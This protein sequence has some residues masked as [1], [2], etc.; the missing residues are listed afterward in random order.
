MKA[1][2][3]F[4]SL[5]IYVWLLILSVGIIGGIF[6]WGYNSH[7]VKQNNIQTSESVKYLE[8]VNE[9]VF[10]N[11]GIGKIMQDSN[12]MDVFDHD[13]PFT[14]KEALIVIN[15][16]AKLGIKEPV[17]IIQ[18]GEHSFKISI[19]KFKVIGIELDK[20]DPYTPYNIKGEILSYSTK[21]IDTGKLVTKGLSNKEQKKYLKK[22][23][24]NIRDSAQNYY[25]TVFKGINKNNKINIIFE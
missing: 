22:Y 19:P 20:K 13:I 21:N 5:K 17:K 2:K 12:V 24:K 16:N 8:E 1:I 25:N 11:V 6:V 9:V 10:L 18:K 4:F 3:K 7:Q 23:D 14:K 15:Y